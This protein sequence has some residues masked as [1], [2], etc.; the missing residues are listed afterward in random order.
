MEYFL[1]KLL[2]NYTNT[3]SVKETGKD[4]LKVTW[5]WRKRFNDKLAFVVTSMHPVKV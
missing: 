3:I 5:I 4:K 1:R 2:K